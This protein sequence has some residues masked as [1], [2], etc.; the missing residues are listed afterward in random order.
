MGD[1]SRQHVEVVVFLLGVTQLLEHGYLSDRHHIAL[2]AIKNQGQR[3]KNEPP[4]DLLAYVFVN[5]VGVV[6]RRDHHHHALPGFAKDVVV[7]Q[8]LIE[9]D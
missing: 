2:L 1:R 5:L 8:Q 7:Q 4:P 3:S 6:S 9:R